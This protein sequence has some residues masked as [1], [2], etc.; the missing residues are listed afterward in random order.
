MFLVYFNVWIDFPDEETRS[1]VPYS[2]TDY[3]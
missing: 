1:N 2:T 3:A